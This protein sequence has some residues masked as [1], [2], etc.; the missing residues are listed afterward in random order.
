MGKRRDRPLMKI[1]YP[2]IKIRRV[3]RDPR[4]WQIL[5]RYNAYFKEYAS[6][7]IGKWL[8]CSGLRVRTF[9]A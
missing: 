7:G 9:D 8:K 6:M 4:K 3:R 5:L 1:R 2:H